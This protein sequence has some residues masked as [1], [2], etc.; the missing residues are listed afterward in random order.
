MKIT[1]DDMW[2]RTY[3]RLYQK[4]CSTTCEIPIGIYRTQETSG[5]EASHVS[6]SPIAEKWRPFGSFGIKHCVR[7]RPTVSPSIVFQ[8]KTRSKEAVYI[9]HLSSLFLIILKFFFISTADN[10][11]CSFSSRIS[12]HWFIVL[13]SRISL[14]FFFTSLFLSISHSLFKTLLLEFH[15]Y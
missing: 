13:F 3:G 5:A 15:C 11:T 12:F 1:K 14:H 8:Q 9:N 2:I 10:N 4:L 7:L 6:S